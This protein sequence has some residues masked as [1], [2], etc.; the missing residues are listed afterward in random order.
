MTR[1]IGY[2]RVSTGEQADSG[3]GM[4]AQR[5][6]IDAECGRRGWDLV[7]VFED[8][9]L[10]G[11][12]T[13]RPGFE[14]AIEFLRDRA[15][16]AIVVSNLDRLTRSLK[17]FAELMELARVEGWN[18][19]ALDLG[20]DLSTPAG[21]FLAH[22]MASVAQWERRII[23]QRTK[24]ALAVKKS[25]GVKLGGPTK[26]TKETREL[27]RQRRKAG[28]SLRQIAELLNEQGVTTGRGGVRWYPSTVAAAGNAQ[29]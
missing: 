19:V 20:V 23:S 25:Q 16:E 2:V 27:I 8:A 13:D 14:A 29:D 28:E 5:E 21:E 18:L 4:Q 6:R 26:T 1:V 3:A 15:A 24:S 22:V 12:S 10:S 17:D 9:G 7:R 11:K